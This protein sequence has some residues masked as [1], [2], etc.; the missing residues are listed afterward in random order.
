MKFANYVLENY[1][2]VDSKFSPT[3]W[4][5]ARNVSAFRPTLRSSKV[6]D[7]RTN[8]KRLCYFLLVLH[9]NPGPILPRFRDIR[10]FVR[11]KPLFDTPP[12]FRPK[13]QG[14]PLG[15]DP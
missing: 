9:S 1:I 12:L 5:Q 3:L 8:R 4:A 10:A 11:R 14:V 7:F 13:F 15:V 6:V 2:D